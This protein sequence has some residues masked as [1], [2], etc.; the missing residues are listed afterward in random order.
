M[1]RD[2]GAAP[3][4]E[5]RGTSGRVVFGAGRRTELGA[6][7]DRLGLGRILV[8]STPGRADLA[9]EAAAALGERLAGTHPRAAMHVP[10]EVGAA[11]VA[12]ARELGADGCVAIGGGS[13]IGLGK[14]VARDTGIPLVAVPSTYSGSEATPIWGETTDGRKRTGQDPRVQPVTVIYDPELTRSM[15]ARLSAESGMNALA[16][17]AEALYAPE[18]SPVTALVAAQA[19]R[20]LAHGLPLVVTDPASD[21]GRAEVLQGA[22]LAGWCLASSTMSL[23][24]KL[25]HTLGG[26]F[27]LPHAP[28]HAVVLAHVLA[29]N[30]PAAPAAELALRQAL[31]TDDVPARVHRLGLELGA[32]RSLAELGMPAGGIERVVALATADPYANPRPVT[33]EGIRAVVAAAYAGDPPA[34]G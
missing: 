10:A 19:A 26:T 8:V 20:S 7:V 23:H 6:E 3:R 15:P 14:I 13:A 28:T 1:T 27:D 9:D 2:T 17:A 24:H 25:C 16:H 30:L 29:F 11:A 21:P 22:W 32:G 18:A 5:H 12:R 4:F 34:T 31:D 33:A